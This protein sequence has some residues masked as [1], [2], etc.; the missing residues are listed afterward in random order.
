MPDAIDASLVLEGRH[1]RLLPLSADHVDDLLAAAT[2]DRSTFGYTLVPAD[3]GAMA[4]WIQRSLRQRDQGGHLPFATYSVALGRLVGSTR[5]YDI[6]T[7]EWATGRPDAG[8]T[9]DR[10]NIGHT[11][12]DPAVQRSPVNTEAKLLMLDHAFGAWRAR[13]VRL[14]TDVRNARSRAAIARLGCTL[15]GVLRCDRPGVDGSVRDS[16]VYSMLAA[17]WPAH[18]LRL[19]GRLDG[20][21]P[22]DEPA[23]PSTL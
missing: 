10:A 16:A 23:P 15:D 22:R 17:E 4:T 21:A 1:V 9:V 11:W 18:R 8:R 20:G 6:E 13:A 14:W 3:R 5:Y 12:L 7:W 19:A 2:G